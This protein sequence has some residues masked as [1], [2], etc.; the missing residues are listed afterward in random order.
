MI[1]LLKA[2]IHK[3]F[4]L[5]FRQQFGL[6]SIFLYVFASF[7]IVFLSF[8]EVTGPTWITLYWIVVL[9]GAV[10]AVLKAFSQEG[11]N[12]RIYYIG[13]VRPYLI[14]F[15]KIIYNFCLLVVIA[16]GSLILFS[17]LTYYPVKHDFY[18]FIA[19][20]LGM[21]GLSFLFTIMSAIAGHTRNKSS[22]MMILSL[23]VVLPILLPLVKISHKCLEEIDWQFVSGDF[24]FLIAADLLIFGVGLI[25]F[26]FLW[27]G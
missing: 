3:D 5:D 4:L 16:T 7:F 9:F 26:P 22:M 14:L 2:L 8:G 11:E 6:G 24:L 19:L 15:S 23:P 17:V 25:L 10:N 20:F 27:R 12:R 21:M 18:F 1:T 13:I